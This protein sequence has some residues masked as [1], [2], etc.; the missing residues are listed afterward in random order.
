MKPISRIG[1]VG[2]S[3]AGIAAALE[4]RRCGFEGSI[5]VFDSDSRTPYERPPLSK[6]LGRGTE[7]L[8]VPIAP[9][10]AY[11]DNAIDLALGIVVTDL[12]PGSRHI[13]AGGEKFGFDRMLLASGAR[14]RKLGCGSPAENLLRAAVGRRCDRHL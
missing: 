5:T 7:E 4:L 3:A 6:S 9:A 2:A 1:I 10:D 14:A 11:T 13:V 8:L 12:D